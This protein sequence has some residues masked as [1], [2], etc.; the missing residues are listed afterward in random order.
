MRMLRRRVLQYLVGVRSGPCVD[1]GRLPAC[2]HEEP[3]RIE[4]ERIANSQAWLKQQ[5][6]HSTDHRPRRHRPKP[7][8]YP[9]LRGPPSPLRRL[10][11][12]RGTQLPTNHQ[13]RPPILP[14]NGVRD[15]RKPYNIGIDKQQAPSIRRGSY[16]LAND[17]IEIAAIHSLISSANSHHFRHHGKGIRGFLL[18]PVDKN[19]HMF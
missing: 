19:E 11:P 3:K 14:T 4:P 1:Y 15:R 16:K 2:L 6:D 13:P 7:V 10:I 17:R 18:T 8:R 5:I 12:Q 9:D